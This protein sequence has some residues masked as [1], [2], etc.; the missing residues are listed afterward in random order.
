MESFLFRPTKH[1]DQGVGSPYGYAIIATYAA[2]NRFVLM[3]VFVRRRGRAAVPGE[4]CCNGDFVAAVI[5]D[6]LRRSPH[7]RRI[8]AFG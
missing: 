7:S 8:I 6:A 2:L 3:P 1:A 4:E 5:A